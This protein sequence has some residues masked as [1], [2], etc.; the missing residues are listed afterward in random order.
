MGKI[1][2]DL[3]DPDADADFVSLSEG[4]LAPDNLAALAE[5]NRQHDELVARASRAALK[6]ACKSDRSA[7][8]EAKYHARLDDPA[9][10]PSLYETIHNCVRVSPADAA[11]LTDVRKRKDPE[12][13][14]YSWRRPGVRFVA[15]RKRVVLNNP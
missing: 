14:P 3:T 12:M 15:P 13:H 7:Y 6:G 8:V 1:L 2:A 9:Y 11:H 10:K 5:R 4:V